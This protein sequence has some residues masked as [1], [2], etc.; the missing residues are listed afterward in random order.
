[1]KPLV[2]WWAALDRS[3]RSALGV[4][5]LGVV[6]LVVIAVTASGIGRAGGARVA[7]ATATATAPEPTSSVAI[8]E[9]APTETG[10]PQISTRWKS[11]VGRRR[12]T[13][14]TAR[15]SQ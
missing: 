4:A 5:A 10:M 15:I 13:A 7:E 14:F 3:R 11:I 12:A 6:L 1:M 2:E 9:P 8:V